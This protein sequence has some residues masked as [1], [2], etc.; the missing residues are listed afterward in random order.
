MKTALNIK[1]NVKAGFSLVEMLVVIAVIGIMAAIAIPTISS[2][3]A[4]A[5]ENK[6]KRNAQN[7]A[8]VWSAAIAAGYSPLAAE[9]T[10]TAMVEKLGNGIAAADNDI[11]STFKVSMSG[12]E[13]TAAVAYLGV[14][15]TL[16]KYPK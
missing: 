1:K 9:T 8:S 16:L 12:T 14:D 10:A 7:L 3:T 11:G 2:M 15:G 6:S 13:Q 4:K 5:K